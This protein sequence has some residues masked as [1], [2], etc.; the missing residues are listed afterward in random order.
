[1]NRYLI[2]F[3]DEETR[4]DIKS[5][6]LKIAQPVGGRTTLE[7]RQFNL[8]THALSIIDGL[9]INTGEKGF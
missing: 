2:S 5:R 4:R 1:M 9:S 3:T 6:C 8:R 7:P